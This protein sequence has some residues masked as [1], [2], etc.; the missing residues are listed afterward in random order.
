MTKKQDSISKRHGVELWAEIKKL[1]ESKHAPD[2]SRTKAILTAEFDL[3]NFPSESTIKRRAKDELWKR[4]VPE[5]GVKNFN[6]TYTPEFWLCVRAVYE[7][8][9]KITYKRLRELVQNELQCEAFPSADAINSKAKLEDW[10]RLGELRQKSDLHL[11]KVITE[12]KNIEVITRQ[13]KNKNK[14]NDDEYQDDDEEEEEIDPIDLLDFSAY[15]KFVESQ[16]SR[17]E[18]L[19][20]SSKIKQKKMSEVITQ[21]RKR[22][23]TINDIGDLLSDQIVTNFALMTAPEILSMEG[24]VEFVE[25]QNKI[26]SKTVVIYN[27]LTFGRRESIKLEMQMYGVGIEDLRVVDQDT[28]MKTL[29]DDTAYEEQKARLMQQREEIAK[30]NFYINSGGLEKD[31]AEETKRR[32]DEAGEGNEVDE[33]EFMDIEG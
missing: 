10:S 14:K 9:P 21:A 2:Y 7:S 24:A 13:G 32:M 23:S 31:V 11:K 6:S 12:V 18:K 27:E 22:L 4:H 17:V 1:Y 5:D 33:F 26:L 19:L 8:N 16:K 3:S 28:R 25:R 20:M 15:H 29:N 30:R